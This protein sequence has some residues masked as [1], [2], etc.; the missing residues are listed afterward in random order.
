MPFCFDTARTGKHVFHTFRPVI[1]KIFCVIIKPVPAQFCDL[2][3]CQIPENDVMKP[4]ICP[5]QQK[6]REQYDG[7]DQ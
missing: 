7:Y 5:D 1:F 4:E 3:G 2:V 6:K